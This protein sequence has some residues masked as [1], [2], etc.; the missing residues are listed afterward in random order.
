MEHVIYAL[1][2]PRTLNVRYIGFTRCGIERRLLW[3]ICEAR[4]G[5]SFPRCRWIRK[6]LAAGT[7]PIVEILEIVT[8]E[9]WQARERYWIAEFGG[10]GKPGKLLN[11]TLGGEASM[12]T[13]AIAA[14]VASS[15]RGKKLSVEHKKKIG[16][17]FRGKK[18]PVEHCAKVSAAK[19]GK[20]FSAAHR[21]ALAVAQRNAWSGGKYSNRKNRWL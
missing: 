1:K 9:T 21:E 2:C 13:P 12:L 16:D 4:R 14:K 15:N 17:F 6:L 20:K 18:L 19:R 11:C 8:A 7:V 5:G 3:H 10:P